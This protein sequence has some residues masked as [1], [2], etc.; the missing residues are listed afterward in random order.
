MFNHP[1]EVL[2]LLA[3][4]PNLSALDMNVFIFDPFGT[5]LP[6]HSTLSMGSGNAIHIQK[7][8]IDGANPAMPQLLHGLLN[9]PFVLLPRE[10]SITGSGPCDCNSVMR[11]LYETRSV[12]EI[13]HLGFIISTRMEK[14]LEEINVAE[15]PNLRIF[16]LEYA[17]EVWEL[18]LPG[19]GHFRTE[20][21]DICHLPLFLSG[22]PESMEE[23]VFRFNIPKKVTNGVLSIHWDFT[24]WDMLDCVFTELHTRI[25]ALRITFYFVI[26]SSHPIGLLATTPQGLPDIAGAL[27]QRL[28]GAFARNMHIRIT[29]S[30]SSNTA[31]IPEPVMLSPPQS[32]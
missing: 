23:L 11:L 20:A 2:Q 14:L 8:H 24:N 10:V 13:L 17:Y 5:E 22:L 28:R 9:S 1:A 15:Y 6:G 27:G 3:L 21:G 16:E 25:P 32:D 26:A 19:I 29:C 12:I 31:A 4:F 18:D 7:L 30:D